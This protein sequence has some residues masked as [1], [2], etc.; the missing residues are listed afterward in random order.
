[1]HG[2]GGEQE[3]ARCGLSAFIGGE[4][5]RGDAPSQPMRRRARAISYH[6]GEVWLFPHSTTMTEYDPYA[7][8]W[9][10][11]RNERDR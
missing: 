1:V 6:H 11:E 3:P 4:S 8:W 7:S 5:E 10:E 9:E 2:E